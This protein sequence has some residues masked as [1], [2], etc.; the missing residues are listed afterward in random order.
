MRLLVNAGSILEDD[1]QL[2][3]AHFIEHMSFNGTRRFPKNE[4]VSYLQSLGVRL[5]GDLNANTGYDE[6]IYILPIPVGDPRM[7]DTGLSILREWAGNA[8][9]ND[10]DID[11]ERG[12]VMAELRSGQAADE[13]VRRQTMPRMFNGSRYASRLPIGTVRSLQTMTPEALRRFYRDWYRPELEAVVVVG[14]VNPD[15]IEQRIK[16]LFADLPAPVKPRVRPER[17]D[18]PPRTA[19]DALLVTDAELPSGRLDLT[20]YVRPQPSLATIGAYDALLKDQLVNRM[21][22]MRLYELTDRPVRPFLAAQAQR[23]PIVRGYEAFVATAAIAGQDPVETT[24]LLATEIERARRFGFTTEELDAAKRD[25]MNRYAEA[26][27]E[28]ETSDSASLADELGRHYFTDEPVPGIAWEYERVKQVVPSLTL[29]A[30]NTHALLVLS[31]PGSQPFVMVAA[32]SAQGATEAALRDAATEV[33]RADITPYKGVKMETQLLEQEPRPGRLVSERNDPALG[34][35]TL[36]YA[37]GV[38]VVLKPTTF[39][40]DEVLLSAA[41]Y[42]GQYLFD[43]A[44]HQNAVHLVQTID[45]MGYGALSPTGLQRLLSTRRANANVS[46]TAYTEEVEGASTRD[47]LAHAAAGRPSEAHEPSPRRG[48]LRGQSHGAQRLSHQPVEQPDDAVPRLHDGHAFRWPSACAARGEGRGPRQDRS[49]TFGRHVSGAVWQRGWNDVRA[50]REL[51]PRRREASRDAVP[52][53]ACRA[54]PGHH[55]SVTSACATRPGRSIARCRRAPTTVP[56]PS[57]TTGS[58]PTRWVRC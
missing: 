30:V 57:S 1:D 27:A 20:T 15:L 35:T 14:E 16:A 18:I 12:V 23:S 34:T 32:P 48:A 56:L 5:G 7:L 17:I 52:W 10:A 58:A 51:C 8:L 33:M 2:G 50:R 4:L 31:E 29:E 13:R 6:T 45:A 21:F 37:N 47:D 39:K 26:A 22:G 25:V 24:R 49:R 53:A 11:T 55:A 42:G 46:L 54:R 43:E 44:D 38:H 41:R 19:P 3:A 28:R 36:E 9:L 40:T